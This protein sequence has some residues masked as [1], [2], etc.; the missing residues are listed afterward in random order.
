[1]PGS[2]LAEK[3]VEVEFQRHAD[4]IVLGTCLGAGDRRPGERGCPV[5]PPLISRKP[6]I[7]NVELISP[8]LAHRPAAGWNLR[9]HTRS[10]WAR[11]RVECRAAAMSGV[12]HSGASSDTRL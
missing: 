6:T 10:C 8:L 11:S 7:V 3:N 5:K 12:P 2:N 9:E 1:V 4:G